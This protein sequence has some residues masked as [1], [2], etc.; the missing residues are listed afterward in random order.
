MKKLILSLAIALSLLSCSNDD[1]PTCSKIKE[2]KQVN[3][4]SNNP[5]FYFVL[6]NGKTVQVDYNTFTS[7][8]VTWDYCY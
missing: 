6:E 8:A 3:D 5:V 1:Q 2:L 7:R 4:S